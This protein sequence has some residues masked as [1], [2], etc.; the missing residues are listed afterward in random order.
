[1]DGVLTSVTFDVKGKP[2]PKGSRISGRRKDGTI[3][4]RPASKGEAPWVAGVAIAAR[5]ACP[6]GPLPLPYRV[7]L[8]FRFARPKKPANG[9]PST[10]I[11][12]LARAVLDGLTHGNVIADDRHVVELACSKEW[13]AGDAGCTV[14]VD[15]VI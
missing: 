11:D 10:D 7:V 13:T 4:T 6:Q 12:K 3:Y 9:Y 14:R 8:V 15:T 5:Q 1:V 2:A